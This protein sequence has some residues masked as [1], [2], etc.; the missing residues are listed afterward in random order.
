MF[1]DRIRDVRKISDVKATIEK[2]D[3]LFIR[4]VKSKNLFLTE[5]IQKMLE[6]MQKSYLVIIEIDEE[7]EKQFKDNPENNFNKSIEDNNPNLKKMPIKVHEAYSMTT[8]LDQK[9]KFPQH[10]INNILSVKSNT[11]I[12]SYKEKEK[13]VG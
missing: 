13:Q 4:D 9:I 6:M 11:N 5:I 3:T 7:Q 8:K 2:V 12:K 1:T 10:I